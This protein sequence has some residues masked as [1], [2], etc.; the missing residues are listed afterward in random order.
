M[1]NLTVVWRA[2]GR[3]EET[4]ATLRK[5]LDVE[6]NIGVQL[7][8]SFVMMPAASVSGFYFAH[9]QSRYFAVGRI[10]RDQVADY[11]RRK[12]Q[13]LATVERWLASNLAY[14]PE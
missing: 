7:T 6:R 2:Q 5:L 14:D 10:G 11:A 3:F 12:G 1:N 13:P 9:P 8:E 4:E